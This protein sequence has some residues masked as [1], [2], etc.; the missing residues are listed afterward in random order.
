MF[1]TESFAK[2]VAFLRSNTFPG[3]DERE[4]LEVNT[5]TIAVLI[6]LLLNAFD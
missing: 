2:P 3:A 4:R 6:L 1:A 5:T